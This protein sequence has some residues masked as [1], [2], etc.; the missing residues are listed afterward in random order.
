MT[1]P[2]REVPV[3]TQE[4]EIQEPFQG[5]NSGLVRTHPESSSATSADPF[6]LCASRILKL[7]L[8]IL[9]GDPDWVGTPYSTRRVGK[10]ETRKPCL[11]LRNSGTGLY[12]AAVSREQGSIASSITASERVDNLRMSGVASISNHKHRWT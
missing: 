10:E 12:G 4:Q 8:V 6:E 2:S 11:S 9:V 3:R 5:G 1:F 7:R